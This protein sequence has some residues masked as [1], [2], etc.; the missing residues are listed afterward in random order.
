MASMF[1]KIMR[2]A[3]RRLSG[4]RAALGGSAPLVGTRRAGMHQAGE[5]EYQRAV[6]ASAEHY[7]ESPEDAVDMPGAVEAEIPPVEEEDDEI[8][9]E[10]AEGEKDI[11]GETEIL[12]EIA[13]P[14]AS[15]NEEL[16]GE[17]ASES[18][19]SRGK[20]DCYQRAHMTVDWTSERI[21]VL[22]PIVGGI[23]V[24]ADTPLEYSQGDGSLKEIQEPLPGMGEKYGVAPV[25]DGVVDP[26]ANVAAY[27]E[28]EPEPEPEPD[29]EPETPA[30]TPAE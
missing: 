15:E 6:M 18:L 20:P 30:E 25:V 9:E 24:P 3:A 14:E 1:R 28:P 4:H 22:D 17:P 10:I 29:P 12:E 13:D 19:G 16:E 23:G 2:S 7:P 11:S 27:E 26:S 21:P 5:H 8:V